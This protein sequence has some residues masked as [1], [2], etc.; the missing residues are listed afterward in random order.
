M[1]SIHELTSLEDWWDLWRQSM[2]SPVLVFKHS[3]SCMISSRA[4][5]HLRNFQK[6][7]GGIVDC[8]MVKVVESRRISNEI[9]K[10]TNIPHKSP[11]LLLIDKQQIIWHT[12][13]WKITKKRI[14]KA[15]C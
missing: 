7:G 3:T 12:S 14:Q 8:Y 4:F 13:H 5:K 6:V 11:Q 15:I 10:V 2:H 9:A 1:N